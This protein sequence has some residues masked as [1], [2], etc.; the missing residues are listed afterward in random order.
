[1]HELAERYLEQAFGGKARRKNAEALES[2][3]EDWLM[4]AGKI[5]APF[6]VEQ[7]AALN[8]FQAA[9]TMHPFTCGG[10]GCG[11]TLVAF[12][13]WRCPNPRCEYTQDWAW[14]GMSDDSLVFWPGGA[15]IA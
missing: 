9:Q 7:Q 3:R 14:F 12:E 11:Q 10:D 1:M 8:R 13:V 4:E 2:F 15:P 5:R 6:S